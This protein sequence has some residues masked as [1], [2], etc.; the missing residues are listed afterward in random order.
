MS[1]IT[2]IMSLVS[3]LSQNDMLKLNV[4]LSQAMTAEIKA[5]SKTSSRKGKPASLGNRA[6]TAYVEHLKQTMPE[7]FGP[8]ALPKER[9]VIAGAIR[10]ENPKAYAAF[11][12]K[13]KDEAAPAAAPAAEAE[14]APEAETE[15][16]AEAAPEVKAEAE[17][18]AEPAPEVKAE[19]EPEAKP[20]KP[21]RVISDEQKAKM[22]AGREAAKAKKAASA[23][24][25][26]APS[27][28]AETEA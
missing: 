6:W 16:K 28:E 19:A 20:S 4:A 14:P 12:E 1:S 23:S 25:S 21:K 17:V 2:E 27:S 8:P 18:K 9:L 24:A 3:Q 7:R 5:N 22:K 26:A 11:C 10:L 13:F 15:V